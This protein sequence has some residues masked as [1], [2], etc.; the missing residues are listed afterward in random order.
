M[1]KL[2]DWQEN[3]RTGW[4]DD[5][6]M[7]YVSNSKFCPPTF[8]LWGACPSFF[9]GTP[10]LHNTGYAG[11]ETCLER[12]R[13]KCGTGQDELCKSPSWR[14]RGG[15]QNICQGSDSTTQRF[16][17]PWSQFWVTGARFDVLFIKGAQKATNKLQNTRMIKNLMHPRVFT[18]MTGPQDGG[19]VGSWWS[20]C[21]VKAFHPMALIIARSH[22]QPPEV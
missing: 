18:P 7:T 14:V 19:E 10:A 8:S 2:L 11:A 3:E 6:M 13:D 5:N 22:L 15:N 1:D 12:R 16:T 21:N 17:V 4:W 20:H 9:Q